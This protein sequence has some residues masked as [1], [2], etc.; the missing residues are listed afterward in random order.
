[1]YTVEV[2]ILYLDKYNLKD[3]LIKHTVGEAELISKGILD[4]WQAA[5]VKNT[6]Q[7]KDIT[8]FKCSECGQTFYS[9]RKDSIKRHITRGVWYVD[10]HLCGLS[11]PTNLCV[12]CCH[13]SDRKKLMKAV[14]IQW[15]R[16]YEA[17]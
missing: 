3:K 1:M 2:R 9:H 15:K 5:F 6:R 10:F 12:H 8:G 11:I 4:F 17:D 16:V 13:N 14:T 7:L